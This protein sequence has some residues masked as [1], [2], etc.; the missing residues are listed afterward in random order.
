MDDMVAKTMGDGNHGND[1]REILSH[2]K[3]FNMRLNLEKC[4]F[5]V[6]GGKFIKFL[7]TSQGIEANLEKCQVILEMRTLS[8]LKEVQQL[9]VHSRLL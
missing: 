3:K 4:V 6:C 7:L 8:T 5:A 9:I 2:V 1:L